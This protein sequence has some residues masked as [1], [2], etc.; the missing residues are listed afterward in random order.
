VIAP[1][2]ASSAVKRITEAKWLTGLNYN[3]S[4]QLLPMIEENRKFLVPLVDGLRIE[5]VW[6]GS[7][8]L[9]LS[10][11]A[12]CALACP[13]CASGRHGLKR[14]L[15]LEE[16][17]RQVRFCRE[18]G[19]EPQRLTLS[20][21]GEPLQ[22]LDNVALF[23]QRCRERRLP[24]SLTTTGTPL[25]RLP[26]LLEQPHN[27]LMLS[28][29]AAMETGYRRLIPNG[30]GPAALR[31]LLIS[32]WPQLSSRRRRKLGVNYLL[33]ADEN[34]Q[35]AELEAL[36]TWLRP[37]PE[38]T[39]HLLSCNPVPDSPFRSPAESEIDRIFQQLRG[40]GIHVRRANRW[41]RQEAG[42]CG[43]LLLHSVC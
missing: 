6:Y 43:T 38:L 35:S 25:E 10:T 24:I 31:E 23:M 22:N 41:R 17:E 19:I 1:L 11:Q 14:N 40:Q 42:G 36:V 28:L 12:G 3:F 9:C 27:G 33:L 20:G 26:Q 37:F 18:Q 2:S 29:H 5:A 30:P 15:T 32:I 8:T 16:L 34:D 21:V 7:G 13:F 4:F 39:L